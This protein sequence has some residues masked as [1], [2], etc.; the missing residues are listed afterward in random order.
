[1]SFYILL[2]VKSAHLSALLLKI[3]V[4]SATELETLNCGAIV[5]SVNILLHV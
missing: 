3:I 5:L 4:T 2:Y 1:M